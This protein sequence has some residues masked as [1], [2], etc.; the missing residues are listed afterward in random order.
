M[1]PVDRRLPM[2]AAAGLLATACFGKFALG[3]TQTIELTPL[4]PG[5]N[6]KQELNIEAD[7]LLGTSVKQALTA[8]S[9]KVQAQSDSVTRCEAGNSSEGPALHLAS[10]RV[11]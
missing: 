7:V 6:V 2:L 1:P 4:L 11:V 3:V 10:F 9:T 8:A 5:A